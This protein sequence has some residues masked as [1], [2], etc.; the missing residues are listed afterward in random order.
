MHVLV[1]S[2]D[3]RENER[4]SGV[5]LTSGLGVPLPIPGARSR[6]DRIDH[7][8]S[9][10]QADDDKVFV[11]LDRDRDLGGIA[12]VFGQ[13]SDQRSEACRVGT[14]KPVTMMCPSSP[15]RV[16]S[17]CFSAQSMP[18]VI[19]MLSLPIRLMSSPE[20]RAAT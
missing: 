9:C 11:C 18:Q 10:L 20:E 6:V 1:G 13:E 12:G 7:D 3:A 15:T 17:W 14:D 19:V 4:V 8:A 5:G 16:T 2:E